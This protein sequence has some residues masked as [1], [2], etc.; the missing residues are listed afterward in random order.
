MLGDAVLGDAEL[1]D[2]VVTDAKRMGMC[3]CAFRN[4][5][6]LSPQLHQP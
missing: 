5:P 3:T 6:L 2:A 4:L 1:G